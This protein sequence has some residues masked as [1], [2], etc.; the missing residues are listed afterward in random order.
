MNKHIIPTM[1]ALIL[2]CV[3]QGAQAAIISIK[4]PGNSSTYSTTIDSEFDANIYM[5]SITDFAGF[6]LNFTYD[7]TTL[8]A[9]TLTTGSIFGVDETET[10]A[11]SITPGTVHLAE[12]ISLSSPLTAGLDINAPTLLGTVHFKALATVVNNLLSFAN[13]ILANFNGDSIGGDMQTAFV[14]ITPAAAVP[15]PASIILFA[16][17][18]LALFGIRKK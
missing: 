1:M 8:S 14:T 4:L 12:A 2:A 10:L 16:P 5:D 15:L 18:L 3:F 17:A 13:P 6:D 7:S 9:L 11:N